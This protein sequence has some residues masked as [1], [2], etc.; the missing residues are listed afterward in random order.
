MICARGTSGKLHDD[1]GEEI[2]I[3]TCAQAADGGYCGAE[4]GVAHVGE[5]EGI[6]DE[7]DKLSYRSGS[8]LGF[9]KISTPRV[10]KRIK[11]SKR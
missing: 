8:V 10:K 7:N 3:S 1:I 5:E 4:S 2:Q 9:E 6:E 11:S